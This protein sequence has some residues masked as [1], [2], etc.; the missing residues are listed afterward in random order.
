MI[1]K[2][3]VAFII[4]LFVSGCK[5][6]SISKDTMDNGKKVY[7]TNCLGCHMEDAMG[8]PGLNPPLV[9]S[10]LLLND[11]AKPIRIVLRGSAE[12]KSEPSTNYK[13]IMAPLNNLNDQEI[14]DVLTFARN[15]FG[16]KAPGI[17]AT[18]VKTEREKIK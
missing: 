13:N 2:P 15:S 12:L 16:N 17:T 4:F 14:A 3:G 10:E 5:D 1:P 18:E 9:K 6:D 11:K 7:A 8:V